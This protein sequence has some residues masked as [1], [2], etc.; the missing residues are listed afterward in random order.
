MKAVDVIFNEL[1]SMS[2]TV[3]TPEEI[4]Q[5]ATISANGDKSIGQLISEAMKKVLS[6]FNELFIFLIFLGRK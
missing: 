3:T 5:V 2:K 1:K 4:A 6:I